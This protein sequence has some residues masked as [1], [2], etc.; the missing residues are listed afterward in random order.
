MQ[1]L[2][3]WDHELQTGQDTE[4]TFVVIALCAGATFLLA[5]AVL[6]LSGAFSGRAISAAGSFLRSSPEV[7]NGV[8]IAP[9]VSASPPAAILRI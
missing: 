5:R 9:F 6:Y 7:L 2:D 1:M 4:S 8:G 3:R